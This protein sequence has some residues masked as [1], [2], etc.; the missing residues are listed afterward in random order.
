MTQ[1]SGHIERPVEPRS[2]E[3]PDANRLAAH[4]AKHVEG[5]EGPVRIMQ[6]PGGYSNLTFQVDWPGG[7]CILR[8]PP[9]GAD[10]KSAHD[11]GREY[12]VLSLLRPHY[13]LVPRPIHLCEDPEVIGTPFYLME[14]VT[15]T[16]LRNRIPEGMQVTES[17][18]RNLSM[19]AVKNLAA[20]HDIDLSATG[21]G[22]IGK[23][24]GYVVRQVEGWIGRYERSMTDDVPAMTLAGEWLRANLPP[25]NKPAFL[26]NDY[27]YDNLVLEPGNPGRILCVLDW[28]M[29][30]VGDPL[31]DLGTTLAYWTEAGDPDALKPFSLTWMT[32]NLNREE[33][34]ALYA[35]A[36]DIPRPDM[37]FHYVFGSY[38]VGVIVQQIYARYRKGLT[39]DPRFAGLGHVLRAASDN[40]VKAIRLGRIGNLH[41]Q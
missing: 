1:G 39:K 8:R 38:K 7:S 27:K 36:R 29:S 31:M 9:V 28:E 13:P 6:F 4:L 35:E 10:I 5:F 2:G 19:A 24:E 15:G 22:R 33:V 23:P 18:M 3:A 34:V 16:I 41:N 17:D 25:E 40:A 11:M 30:T 37:L 14:K 21:L 20:L 12:R 26:H 32:G